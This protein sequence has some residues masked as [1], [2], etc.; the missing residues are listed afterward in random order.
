MITSF[1]LC[2]SIVGSKACSKAMI[3]WIDFLSPRA[4]ALS[5]GGPRR[6]TI[7]H[8]ISPPP[9]RRFVVPLQSLEKK[10]NIEHGVSICGIGIK[11]AL[12]A[13][14]R[15]VD[16]ALVVEDI[17]E[18]IPGRCEIQIGP[19]GCPIGGLR[20]EAAPARTQHSPEVERRGRV[21]G[22]DLHNSPIETFGRRDIAPLLGSLGL[23]EDCSVVSRLVNVEN[24]LAGLVGA[25]FHLFDK[26]AVG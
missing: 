7:E 8:E 5:T 23:F 17:G 10:A 26:D 4:A 12:Q 18:V 16:A 14:D 24:E 13:L 2:A 25:A 9:P 3:S 1:G 20:F 6:A 15:L 22:I 11:R 19:D 21:R